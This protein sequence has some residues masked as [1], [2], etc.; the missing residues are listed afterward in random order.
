M[1]F[2]LLVPVKRD[3]N[4]KETIL[5]IQPKRTTSNS[6][7]SISRHDSNLTSDPLHFISPPSLFNY[8]KGFLQTTAMPYERAVILGIIK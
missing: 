3:L 4:E 2:L 1:E 5:L 7:N 6:N 8:F